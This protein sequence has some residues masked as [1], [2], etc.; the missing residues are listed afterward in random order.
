MSA[1][2]THDQPDTS[3]R[4]PASHAT[5]ELPIPVKKATAA[6]RKAKAAVPNPVVPVEKK[7]FRMSYDGT[8]T[9]DHIQYM[10]DHGAR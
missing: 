2:A 8:T 10:I 7:P 6:P 4:K 9:S 1:E 5:E 3:S